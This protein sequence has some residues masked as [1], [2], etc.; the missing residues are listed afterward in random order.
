M[1]ELA[2]EYTKLPKVGGVKRQLPQGDWDEL[3]RIRE[4]SDSH[5]GQH[6]LPDQENF[7]DATRQMGRA[8]HSSQLILKVKK[9]NP[10]LVCEDSINC[11]GNAGF[12]FYDQVGAKQATGA[13][14]KKGIMPEFSIIETDRADLPVRVQY[15]WREVLLRLVRAKQLTL[16]QVLRVFG[17]SHAAQSTAWRRNVQ[18]FRQ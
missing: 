14:F 10:K 5:L 18:K 4:L 9:L 3:A 6:R 17:D 7:K 8:M 11:R 15:G 13:S 16:S 12:Y 1:L 2:N